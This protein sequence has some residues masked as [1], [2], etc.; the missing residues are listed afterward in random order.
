MRPPASVRRTPT[1]VG[2]TVKVLPL[3]PANP[4]VQN[5]TK[6]PK[7][8]RTLENL[9]ACTKLTRMTT[10]IQFLQERLN[11]PSP[12]EDSSF[13][14][15]GRQNFKKM[16]PFLTIPLDLPAEQ[17]FYSNRDLTSNY[18]NIRIS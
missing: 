13:D 15:G 3:S 18:P 12:L 2:K 7:H 6:N 16:C 10:Y 9:T 1:P 11:L 8:T 17:N 5:A 14:K 4:L